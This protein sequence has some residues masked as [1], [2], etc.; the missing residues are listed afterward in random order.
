MVNSR[1]HKDFLETEVTIAVEGV[2]TTFHVDATEPYNRFTDGKL[3]IELAGAD[4]SIAV[5]EETLREAW[6]KS[7]EGDEP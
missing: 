5:P 1:F 3:F 7:I 2:E 6:E 4:G